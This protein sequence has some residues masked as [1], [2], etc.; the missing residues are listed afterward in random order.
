MMFCIKDFFSKCD[1]IR[2]KLRTW[3]HLLKKSLME[4]LILCAALQ[5]ECQDNFD[6]EIEVKQVKIIGCHVPLVPVQ[7]RFAHLH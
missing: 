4:N 6:G 1:Q 2:R 7:E 3:P 5:E